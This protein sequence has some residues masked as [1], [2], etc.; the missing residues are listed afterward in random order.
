M[1]QIKTESITL[2]LALT[3]NINGECVLAA[4]DSANGTGNIMYTDVTT[5][6]KELIERFQKEFYG[7]D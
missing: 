4:S 3:T 1:E 2:Y 5:P 6:I 7:T